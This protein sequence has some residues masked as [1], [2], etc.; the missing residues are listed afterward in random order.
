MGNR[1]E[2]LSQGA[3]VGNVAE[4]RGS[5][6]KVSPCRDRG[7]ETKGVDSADGSFEGEHGDEGGMGPSSRSWKEVSWNFAKKLG[8]SIKTYN[9]YA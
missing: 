8:M 6:V 3:R 7:Q 5:N 2:W 4:G 1:G 9:K